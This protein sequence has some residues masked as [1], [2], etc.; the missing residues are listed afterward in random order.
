M[1]K[2]E[3]PEVKLLRFETEDILTLSGLLGDEESDNANELP[4]G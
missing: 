2:F 3:E 1:K 4:K